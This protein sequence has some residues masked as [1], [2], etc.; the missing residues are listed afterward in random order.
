MLAGEDLTPKNPLERERRL[1]IQRRKQQRLRRHQQT[2]EQ[3]EHHS[4]DFEC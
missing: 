2:A 1:Q 3:R 4:I